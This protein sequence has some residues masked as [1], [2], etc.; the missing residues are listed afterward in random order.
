MMKE[1]Y[2]LPRQEKGRPAGKH[3]KVHGY[4]PPKTVDNHWNFY[5]KGIYIAK[6]GSG[7]PGWFLPLLA[8]LFIV[9]LVFW[10]APSAIARWQSGQQAV[11]NNEAN[12]VK[13]I[14]GQSTRVVIRSV[15]DVFEQPD[16]KAARLTQALYNEPVTL[17]ET[18]CPYGFAAVRLTD[19]TE[20]FMMT[21]DLTEDRT[22]VEPALYTQKLVI[23]SATKRVM[24]HATQG[25]MLVEVMMGTVLYA[26]YRGDGISRVHLPDGSEGWIS[27]EGVIILPV[28]GQ[29]EVPANGA[30]YFCSSAL[31]FKQVTV[32]SNGQSVRGIS[33]TGIVRLAAAVNGMT[34]PRTLAGLSTSGQAL[35]LITQEE[36][37]LVDLSQLQAGDLIFLADTA[38]PGQIGDLA[39]YT[40]TNQILYAR[41]MHSSIQLLD[42]TQNEDLWK[43]IILVRRLF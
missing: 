12:A 30:R 7:L 2:Q 23:A 38:Q 4:V 1:P 5:K 25:T 24:S 41:P 32:L 35:S 11:Q 16:L 36:S 33:T 27:D 13:M 26:D 28:N 8:L 17:R 10:A 34:V 22:S 39:I 18:A 19:G 43:R 31:T 40:D 42:L 37:G 14:Y 15:A 9:V 20:G 21:K 6:P 29:I 3:Q